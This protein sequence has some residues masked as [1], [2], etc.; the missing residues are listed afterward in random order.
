MTP[1]LAIFL[2]DCGASSTVVITFSVEFHLPLRW[3]FPGWVSLWIILTSQHIFLSCQQQIDIRYA[4]KFH[5][6]E[7]LVSNY[8]P[9]DYGDRLFSE[10]LV[11]DN[12]IFFSH[13]F[14][15]SV[16]PSWCFSF[17]W[18]WLPLS[19]W[20]LCVHSCIPDAHAVLRWVSV[21]VCAYQNMR[22]NCGFLTSFLLYGETKKYCLCYLFA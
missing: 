7:N 5:G 2:I 12:L 21:H 8:F 19:S 13:S 18:L 20:A 3:R 4:L 22:G 17:S 11:C 10:M 14:C 6:N 1:W 15:F 16:W 9:Y